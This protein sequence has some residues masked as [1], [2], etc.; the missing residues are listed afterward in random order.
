MIYK[1]IIETEEG[2]FFLETENNIFDISTQEVEQIGSMLE[3]SIKNSGGKSW[4]TQLLEENPGSRWVTINGN[5]VLIR[6]NEDGTATVVFAG[7]PALE[8]LKLMPKEHSENEQTKKTA[9]KLTKEQEEKLRT[10]GDH[11]KISLCFIE[12]R[13]TTEDKV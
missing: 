12:P 3:K 8:H 1:G 5:R 6:G 10:A 11:E 7:N 9:K 2:F 13:P 4:S